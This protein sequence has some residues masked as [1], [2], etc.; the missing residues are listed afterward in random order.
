M[1]VAFY[2]FISLIMVML[3][4]LFSDVCTSLDKIAKAL[5]RMDAWERL[6]K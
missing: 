3:I 6:G 4:I 1:M 5:E 2:I